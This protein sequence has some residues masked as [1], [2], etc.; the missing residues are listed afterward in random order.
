LW[1][2]AGPDEW[3][4]AMRAVALLFWLL[5]AMTLPANAADTPPVMDIMLALDNSGSMKQNDPQRLLPRVVTEFAGRLGEDDRLGIVTFDQSA[6]TLLPL[7]EVK[8]NEFAAALTAALLR[9]NYSGRLTDIPG[10]LEEARKEIE[11]HGRSD[12]QRIVVLLTDGEIDLGSDTRNS[13]RK[14]WLRE[15]ILPAVNRQGVRVFGITL[16]PDADVELIQSMAEAT[17]GNYF[18]LLKAEEIPAVF[19]AIFTRLQEI[20]DRQVAEAAAAET[21]ERERLEQ[22]RLQR[23]RMESG[24][25]ERER[26]ERDR[27]ER[28]QAQRERLEGE[29]ADREQA[30]RERFERDRTEREQAERE[31]LERERVQREQAESERMLWLGGLLAAVVL[32]GGAAIVF[33]VR[34]R[35]HTPSVAVPAARLIDLGGQTG[36]AELRIR[37]PL[38]R[39]GKLEDGNDIVIKS[40]GMSRAHALIEFK[41]GDFLVRDLRSTNGTFLNDRPVSADD[42]SGQMLKHGDILRF[43]PYSFRFVLDDMEKPQVDGEPAIGQT[44][45]L[46]QA[47]V[48]RRAPLGAGPAPPG[49][50]IQKQEGAR[51]AQPV[52]PRPTIVKPADRPRSSDPHAVDVGDHCDVHRARAAVARCAQCSHLICEIED[53]VDQPNGGKACRALV[54][55]GVCPHEAAPSEARQPA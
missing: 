53:P 47:P 48:T 25:E 31:R 1:L 22:E 51:P 34:R 24:Q 5:V 33:V 40:E 13:D 3:G 45:R 28:E 41:D 16:T 19:N 12:A 37:D 18:R 55:G 49:E 8:A 50:T 6:R 27:A 42:R 29:R 30:G 36:E 23:E 4:I 54:E 14:I 21:R 2:D 15:R 20:R 39:I 17:Q 44:V 35:D 32:L 43:G 46:D 26:L 9:V 52:E 7:S 38:T 11:M 10:G